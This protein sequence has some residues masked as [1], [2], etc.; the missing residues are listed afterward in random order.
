MRKSKNK[1]NSKK[2]SKPQRVSFQAINSTFTGESPH[3]SFVV[4]GVMLEIRSCRSVKQFEAFE[5]CLQSGY[6][7]TLST[8]VLSER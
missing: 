6:K 4:K 3:I 2:D 7:I 5:D 8:I 1:K